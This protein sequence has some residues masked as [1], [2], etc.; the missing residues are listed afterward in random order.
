[1]ARK[2]NVGAELQ[3]RCHD[4]DATGVQ[5][6]MQRARKDHELESEGHHAGQESY[7]CARV[8]Q[9]LIER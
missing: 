8:E 5:R 2:Q 3:A 1:M 9:L 4:T 6:W 7:D